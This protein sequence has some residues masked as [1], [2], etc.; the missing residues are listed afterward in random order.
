MFSHN[1]YG[2]WTKAQGPKAAGPQAPR[3]AAPPGPVC[4]RPRHAEPHAPPPGPVC[5]RPRHGVGWGDINI[6]IDI[7][8]NID[9]NII[10]N[11]NYGVQSVHLVAH[12]PNSSNKKRHSFLKSVRFSKTLSIFAN[13]LTFF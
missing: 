11:R 10:I 6:H 2:P 13:I 3:R 9:I 1:G 5:G 7:N 4:G 12:S 8:I